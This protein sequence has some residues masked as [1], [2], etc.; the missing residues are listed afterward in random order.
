MT[1]QTLADVAS[2]EQNVLRKAVIMNLIRYSQLMD[3]IPWENVDALT[4]VAVRWKN[5]PTVAFRKINAGY[6]AGNGTFEQIYET[7]YVMGGDI[8]FDRLFEKIKNYIRDP[9][10]EQTQMKL[11]ALALN[12]NDYF[13]NG[14]QATDQDGFEGLKKRVSL[15][16]STQSVYFAAANAAAADPTGSVAAARAFMDKWD[17]VHG[18]CN[19]GKV[20][21]FFMNKGLKLGFA[22]VIRY[23][24][25]SGG[26]VLD[27]TKDLLGRDILTYKGVPFYDVGVTRDQSTE[28]ITDTETAGD[29]GADA[30]S[31][32]AVS[33]GAD[34]EGL[35]GIQLS[36]LEVYDPLNGG[37]QETV[38]AKLVRLEWAC[39]LANFGA[40]SITRGRNLEG[41]G[42]WT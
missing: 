1:A 31:V 32:Y 17:E 35:T 33:F 27:V 2:L 30:T 5:L 15:M 38:P 21:A 11:K 37:E 39:G 13:I 7:V 10:V 8:N 24:Q 41:V 6:T 36:P 28:I 12:F 16:P 18:Y 3:V 20:N 42:G 22:K 23:A 25:I 9:K 29:A 26:N 34:D 40:H 4:S 14:D 19:D